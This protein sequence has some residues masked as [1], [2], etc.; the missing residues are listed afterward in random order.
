MK[1]QLEREIFRHL[2]SVIADE[3]KPMLVMGHSTKERPK[4]YISIDCEDEIPFGDLPFDAGV[5]E[6]PVNIAVAD[7]AHDIDYD[8]QEERI[9]AIIDALTDFESQDPTMQIYSFEFA[10]NPDARD[11]NNIGNVIN[12]MAIVQ[13]L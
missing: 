1:L 10:E 7:S 2:N 12:Y 11:D 6:I 13:F 4:P 9:I 5:F 3:Y 8:I